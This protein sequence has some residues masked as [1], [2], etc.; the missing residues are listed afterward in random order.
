MPSPCRQTV[1][2]RKRD[3]LAGIV[4]TALSVLLFALSNALAKWVVGVCPVGEMLFVRCVVTLALLAPFLTRRDLATARHAGRLRLHGLRMA[5]SAVEVGCFYWALTA[6]PLAEITTLYLAGAIYVTGL[7]AL[8]LGEPVGWRRWAAVLAGFGG[9]LIALRPGTVAITVPALV[10]V[11]G[12]LLYA[13][14]LVATRGLRGVP[15]TVLVGTQVAA[16]LV[17]A[18]TTA[19]GWVRPS[20]AEAGLMALVG[21]VSMAGYLCLNRGLQLAQAS[22]LAPMQYGS[23]VWAV[24]LG[25]VLF[26]EVPGRSTLAG[27]AVIVA[28]GM[29]IVVRERRVAVR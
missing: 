5:C 9:V 19:P 16:L 12:S 20:A 24:V 3:P 26:G 28:A 27:A 15:N 29:F 2:A 8:F 17:L 21:V 11:A 14:S 1:P 7:S 10:A 22:V 6:L 23:I 4:L 13:V 25:Y 18:G